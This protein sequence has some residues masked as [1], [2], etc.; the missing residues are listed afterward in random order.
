MWAFSTEIPK[1]LRQGQ[2]DEE[3]QRDKEKRFKS[4]GYSWVKGSQGTREYRLEARAATGEGRGV[5]DVM[6]RHQ[7]L[8]P[9]VPL[10]KCHHYSMRH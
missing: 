6:S 10:P 3:E 7:T 2:L 9:F 1:Y 4:S 5:S 8:D